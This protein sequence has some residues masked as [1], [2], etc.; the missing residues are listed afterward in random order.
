MKPLSRDCSWSIT[1]LQVRSRARAK[2]QLTGMLLQQL[3]H[4]C[5]PEDQALASAPGVQPL[6][7]L[8]QI[9]TMHG[10]GVWGWSAL[11][12]HICSITVTSGI[13]TLALPRD[14]PK[15]PSRTYHHC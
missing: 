1:R 4:E 2:P 10:K 3:T 15:G 6:G 8:G 5:K 14:N 9:Q 11:Q 13:T 12:G 7:S